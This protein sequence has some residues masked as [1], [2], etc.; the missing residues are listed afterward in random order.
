MSYWSILGIERTGDAAAI[1]RAYAARLK[2]TRPDEDPEGFGRL[3]RAYKQALADAKRRPASVSASPD[4]SA[5]EQAGRATVTGHPP[6]Q[7]EDEAAS[8]VAAAPERELISGEPVV[9]GEGQSE[10]LQAAW[11]RLTAAASELLS[12]SRRANQVENWRFLEDEEALYDF[13]FKR[14]FSGFLFARI[15]EQYHLKKPAIGYLD[16]LFR[17]SE[18]RDMLELQHGYED[19]ELLL[20][21]DRPS[22]SIRW[23][24]PKHHTGP[25]VYGGYYTRIFATLLDVILMTFA[26]EGLL[27]LSLQ[28]L[29][30]SAF[31]GGIGLF[32]IAAPIL[33]ATPMQGTPAKVLFGLKVTSARGTRLNPFHAIARTLAYATSTALFKV[34]V[35]INLFINDGRLLHDRLSGSLVVKRTG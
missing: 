29:G 24:C 33:E 10:D 32:L 11:Q 13:G 22:E 8:P 3:H 30:D 2:N 26:Y 23:F 14:E 4:G 7:Q 21:S 28:P 27:R 31:F 20:G 15:T 6:V 34:T 35:W 1:K 19:V 18:Q 12:D 25:L 16:G 5:A 9:P 17:W